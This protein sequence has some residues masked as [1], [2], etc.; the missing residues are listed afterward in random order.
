MS[1]FGNTDSYFYFQFGK[2]ALFTPHKNPP[3][4]A[5]TNIKH[6]KQ[7][8]ISKAYRG[9]TFFWG[10]VPQNG[11]YIFFELTPPVELESVKFASG[12]VEHPSDRSV[13]LFKSL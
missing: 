12:N 2:V 7:Y 1:I 4:K 6:Y 11:D 8:S 3:A 13:G 5:E 9:E 10:L